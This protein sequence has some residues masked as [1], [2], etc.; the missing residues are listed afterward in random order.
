MMSATG[1]FGCVALVVLSVIV[2]GCSRGPLKLA[3]IQMGRALNSDK[4]IATHVTRFK[5]DQTVYVSVLTDGPGSG[6][7]GAKWTFGGRVISEEQKSV[8]YT[9]SAATEFHIGYAGGFPP[10]EYQVELFIDGQP[11]ETRTFRIEP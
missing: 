7:I 8:S 2:A 6:D 11:A 4:S 10:G 9:Q 1:R 5:P 3:A